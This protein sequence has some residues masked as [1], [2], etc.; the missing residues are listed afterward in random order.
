MPS[1]RD[2][3][4]LFPE[5]GYDALHI[6]VVREMYK[7]MS[8]MTLCSNDIWQCYNFRNIKPWWEHLLRPLRIYSC[9]G[10]LLGHGTGVEV[11]QQAHIT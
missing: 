1:L 6:E 3:I 5:Y 9:I 11:V 10:R 7:K 4:C 8:G 2:V